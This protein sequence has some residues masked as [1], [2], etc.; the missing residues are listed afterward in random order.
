MSVEKEREINKL[1]I[2]YR[3]IIVYLIV[4]GL[5]TVVS[6]FSYFLFSYVCSINYLVSN[7]LSWVCAVA[8][9]YV[10]NKIW[11]FQNYNFQLSYITKECFSF[12]GSRVATLLIDM[13]IMFLMVSLL[14]TNDLVA[15]VVVQIVVTVLNYVFSKFLVFK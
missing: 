4:G 6:F 11:V 1:F 14:H 8:F 9:A 15:K 10:T 2:K 3:E 12:V 7:F 5:T 13:F